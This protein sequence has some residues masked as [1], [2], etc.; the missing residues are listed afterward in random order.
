MRPNK[1]ELD[2]RESL[3]WYIEDGSQRLGDASIRWLARQPQ[4]PV[5]LL[6]LAQ[7]APRRMKPVFDEGSRT[8]DSAIERNQEENTQKRKLC[9]DDGSRKKAKSDISKKCAEK[10]NYVPPEPGQ[11]HD[12]VEAQKA[13]AQATFNKITNQ[14]SATSQPSQ[15][16]VHDDTADVAM[17]ECVSEPG[18]AE[19]KV[20]APEAVEV[21]DLKHG[22]KPSQ[23]SAALPV[24]QA[25]SHNE[26]TKVE[27]AECGSGRKPT[28]GVSEKYFEY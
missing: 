1:D 21:R 4:L 7:K 26:S 6:K 27:T 12:D 14:L 5:L 15:K 25:A 13:I 24:L 8:A 20:E 10:D 19:D 28:S 22:D 18:Q 9:A 2:L 3:G 16:A 23:P 17:A 11:I